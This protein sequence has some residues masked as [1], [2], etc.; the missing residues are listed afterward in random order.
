MILEMHADI[1]RWFAAV[2]FLSYWS[3][4]AFL[5]VHWPRDRSKSLSDH[6]AVGS[7][8]INLLLIVVTIETALY[9]LYLYYWLIPTFGMPALFTCLITVAL[10][11]HLA[12]FVFPSTQG[13][14]KRMHWLV[15]YITALLFIPS[16]LL[17]IAQSSIPLAGRLAVVT[18][19]ITMIGIS[20]GLYATPLFRR[21]ILIVHCAYIFSLQLAVVLISF[22]GA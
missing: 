21:H 10:I 14:V 5:L 2:A 12:T 8:Q 1:F 16:A 7:K 15:S 20:V 4:V 17:L 3:T 19:L 18:A 9:A 22:L 6:I 11:T 13:R